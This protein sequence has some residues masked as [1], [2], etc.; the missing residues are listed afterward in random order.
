M[1]RLILLTALC[2][3]LPAAPTFAQEYDDYFDHLANLKQ[4]GA[5]YYEQ[6]I[7]ASDAGDA[8]RTCQL[9][10]TAGGKYAA[11]RSEAID[12]L[13]DMDGHASGEDIAAMKDALKFFQEGEATIAELMAGC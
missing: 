1:K 4:Q 8:E 6:A 12:D 7:A 3:I 9:L 5:D 10:I 13:D 11:G 2:L